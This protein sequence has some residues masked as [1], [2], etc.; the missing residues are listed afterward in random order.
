M[1]IHLIVI[2]SLSSSRGKGEDGFLVH[3]FP[4][5]GQQLLDWRVSPGYMNKVIITFRLDVCLLMLL[6]SVV[7]FSYHQPSTNT[8]H[9]Y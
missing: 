5:I 6:V 4:S 1:W 2:D 9:L 3:C 7:I 8:G